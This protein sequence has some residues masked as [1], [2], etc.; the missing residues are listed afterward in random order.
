QPVERA[1]VLL[2]GLIACGLTNW[3]LILFLIPQPVV[4]FHY[5]A[6]DPAFFKSFLGLDLPAWLFPV[7]SVR[8]GRSDPVVTWFY[9]RVPR[10]ESIPWGAWVKPLLAWGIFALAMLATLAAI[11]RMV[12]AQWSANERLP[13]PLVQVQ[14]ALIEPPRPGKGLNDLFLSPWLWVG[15]GGVF[16]IHSLSALN[17]YQPRYFPT[18]SLGYNFTG[19]FADPPWF[20]LDEKGKVATVAFVVIGV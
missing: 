19:L 11:A 15:L 8:E 12:F 1:L 4:P 5:G 17:S 20:Y 14:A 3:G 16:F 6:S 18:I 10:G 2:M 13:F 7:S 9:F